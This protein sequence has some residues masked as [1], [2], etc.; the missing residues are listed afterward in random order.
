MRVFDL[1]VKQ[2]LS[3]I[4]NQSS[5]AQTDTQFIEEDLIDDDDEQYDSLKSLD[6]SFIS[7][8]ISETNSTT[9]K[10]ADRTKRENLPQ[11]ELL[12]KDGKVIP[13]IDFTKLESV[14]EAK[15][16][17]KIFDEFNQQLIE[18]GNAQSSSSS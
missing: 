10:S 12:D 11:Q 16:N 15:E 2:K 14:I 8:S 13:F 17:K 5:H 4:E 9:N 18:L 3:T 6:S 1:N 7:T